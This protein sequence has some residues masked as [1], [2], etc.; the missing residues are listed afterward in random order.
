LQ[1]KAQRQL[2]ADG[3]AIRTVVAQNHKR[4]VRANRVANLSPNFAHQ[5]KDVSD[6]AQVEQAE[7]EGSA[8]FGRISLL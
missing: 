1:T 3:I 7:F 2:R 4:L 5:K 8:R 6:C